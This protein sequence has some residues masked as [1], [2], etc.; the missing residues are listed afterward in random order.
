MRVAVME[1]GINQPDVIDEVAYDP[2]NEELAL[3]MHANEDW[4]KDDARISEIKA[5]SSK[6]I[7]FAM[8]GQMAE[9]FPDHAD[10]KIRIQL[11]CQFLPNDKVMTFLEELNKILMKGGMRLVVN[12]TEAQDERPKESK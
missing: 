7:E 1:Q 11:D 10:G 5:K 3:I 4:S 2:D 6:Y 8:N 9:A 12:C